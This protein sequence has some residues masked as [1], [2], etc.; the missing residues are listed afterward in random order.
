MMARRPAWKTLAFVLAG[1]L[2][3]VGVFFAWV[4]AVASRR[5]AEL[6]KRVPLLIAEARARDARRPVLRGEAVPGSAWADYDQALKAIK[7]AFKNEDLR[8]FLENRPQ[9]DR[10]KA[11]AVVAAH[12]KLL[13]FL[14]AGARKAEGTYPVQFEKG[15]AA[16]IPGL[17]ACR[18]LT[19][20]AACR[21]R[22]LRESGKDVEARAL[23][24][25]ALQFSGDLG[26]NTLLIAEMISLS[27]LGTLFDELKALP[28]DPELA[29]AL[30]V[31]DG[32]FPAHADSMR[33][34][35]ACMAA[36]LF[37]M[38][39]A[40]LADLGE[41]GGA[42]AAWR[43]GFSQRLMFVDTVAV[44]RDL[45]LRMA[46]GSALPWGELAGAQKEIDAAVRAS[47]NPLVRIMVPG[48]AGSER[49]GRERRAQLRLLRRYHGEAGPLDDPFGA[50]LLSDGAKVWSVGPDG[51]DDAGKG[52]W[53][54]VKTG[55]IV[56]E[57]PQK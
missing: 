49:A 28:P 17:L 54:S 44:H 21:A 52:D 31:L 13:D 37:G 19:D 41:T 48:L 43:F 3:L 8:A 10:A 25:D 9:A 22:L 6:E 4:Q 24:L 7:G 29:R 5:W 46:E 36:G 51:V 34:E 32:A 56:L 47:K 35:H 20:L 15:F 57:L 50:Q 27:Q 1:L 2:I 38:G 11:E 53:K 55:D 39:D 40:S 30:G 33:N 26:R 14:Q 16:D 42:L 45:L 18:D 23:L 12:G